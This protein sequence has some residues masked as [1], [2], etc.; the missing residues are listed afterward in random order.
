MSDYLIVPSSRANQFLT[1]QPDLSFSLAGLLACSH[2]QGVNLG[3]GI[4]N[5]TI[6]DGICG[7]RFGKI[8]CIIDFGNAC[9]VA[10]LAEGD[11]CRAGVG[12]NMATDRFLGIG[13]KG[14]CGPRISHHL[15]G[16]EDGHVVLFG[17][18]YQLC[19]HLIQSLLAL[20]KFTPS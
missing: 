6:S 7:L 2:A 20:P 19:K 18:S 12:Q 8:R 15:V 14:H 3:R 4:F 16:D 11:A 17:H 5:T 10:S 13:Y 1:P 9:F